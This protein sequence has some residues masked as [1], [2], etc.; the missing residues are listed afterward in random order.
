[1]M[2]DIFVF[3]LSGK[4]K[5][6]S[7]NIFFMAQLNVRSSCRRHPALKTFSFFF[8]KSHQINKHGI[9]SF[10]RSSF[11][12]LLL[13]LAEQKNTESLPGC[14]KVFKFVAT[15]VDPTLAFAYHSKGL[16]DSGQSELRLADAPAEVV[17]HRAV[18]VVRLDG[19][20]D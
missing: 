3:E 13:L 8:W 15:L 6:E 18:V 10:N 16:C 11:F 12:L 19:R 9:G 1:M 20:L 5:S 2:L 14:W 7:S 4:E 17:T